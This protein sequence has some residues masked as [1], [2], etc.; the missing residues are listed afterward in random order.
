MS[1]NQPEDAIGDETHGENARLVSVGLL[2]AALVD[3]M[4]LTNG[5]R[6]AHWT[7]REPNFAALHGKFEE[8]YD[9]LGAAVDDTAERIVQ[10]GGTAN[11]TTRA[12]GATTRLAPY[13]ADLRDDMAH[14]GALAERYAA[15]V[16]TTCAAIDAAAEAGDADTADLLTGTSRML[17]KAL[18][19]LEAH[20]D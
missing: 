4:D 16:D 10:L 6:M 9:Q 11:C 18:W 8:F 1:E 3:L 5:V 2:N 15:L 20:L 19:M 7:V 17:D 14:V 12:V 13:P